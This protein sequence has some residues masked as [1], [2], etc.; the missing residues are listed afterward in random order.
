MTILK[1][2]APL[3]TE[4]D[5]CVCLI[6]WATYKR[7]NGFRLS[8][9]LIAVPN[10]A[11]LAGDER[12]RAIQ[13]ARLKAQGLKPGVFDYLLAIPVEPYPGLWLEL[14]RTKLSVISD[15]QKKFDRN[16]QLMGW[17]TA[18]CKGWDQAKT[19]IEGYLRGN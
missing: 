6:Q 4:H 1:L 16:M 12:Q 7:H 5:E 8:D 15:E 9:F 19:A 3:P 2:S 17:A 18:I 11:A 13:M 14:K 10:G